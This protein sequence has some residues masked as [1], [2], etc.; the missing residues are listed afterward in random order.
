MSASATEVADTNRPPP[1]DSRQQQYLVT[2]RTSMAAP[3]RPAG[4][5]RH[6]DVHVRAGD[7]RVQR[8]RTRTPTGG[9]W[10]PGPGWGRARGRAARPGDTAARRTHDR[11]EMAALAGPGLPSPGAR[12]HRR[13]LGDRRPAATS[14]RATS[15]GAMSGSGHVEVSGLRIDPALHEFVTAELVPGS[16][17]T[18]DQLWNGLAELVR[19]FA[20]RATR[21]AGGA[22]PAAGVDRRLAPRPPR[23]ARPGGVPGVPR[24]DRLPRAEP[25]EPF[26]IETSGV[27]DEIASI[28]G[29]QLVVPVD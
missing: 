25:G 4:R 27:D 16:G 15:R 8:P 3:G 7:R 20:T 1:A 14:R 26:E 23:R 5:R 6:F 21:P 29:P 22:G 10:P 17:V 28:A 11:A 18:A 24:V 9:G 2:P 13:G 12:E 19:T